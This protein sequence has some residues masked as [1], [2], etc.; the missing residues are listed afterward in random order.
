MSIQQDFSFHAS[1][2]DATHAAI[3]KSG[4][5]MKA[6]AYELW[7]SLKMDTAYARLRGCLNQDRP[8]KLTAD[9]HL[10]LANLTGQ[11]DFVHYCAQECQHSRPEPVS[12]EDERARLQREFVTLA[13]RLEGILGRVG[14]PGGGGVSIR[15]ESE[16]KLEDA[17]AREI[18]TTGFCPVSGERV[19][20]LI[21]QLEV[22]AYGRCDLIKVTHFQ[23]DSV[24]T[25][26]ELKNKPLSPEH[27]NQVCRYMAGIKRAL[28][29][30][31]LLQ[32]YVDV[33]GQLVGPL[34]G[35]E[36]IWM[37]QECGIDVYSFDIGFNEGVYFKEIRYWRKT[38]ESPTK[39]N[40]DIAHEIIRRR[41]W[42]AERGK[43]VPIK[44]GAT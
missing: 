43:V 30:F 8:E 5:A 15:F 40:P 16:A 42:D 25:V 9:E 36:Y 27:L 41:E 28:Y 10:K 31:S 24:V 11:Y 26:M 23:Y 19:D 7:P 4:K 33:R 12:P 2:E 6:L 1:A 44:R 13:K 38:D 22:P 34:K 20:S 17:I 21:R 18:E 14:D 37:F 39:L 35:T 32:E 3:H 29:R